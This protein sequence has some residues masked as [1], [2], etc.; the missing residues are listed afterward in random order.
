M[1]ATEIKLKEDIERVLEVDERILNSISDE[2]ALSIKPEKGET[3]PTY[4]D[5]IF[6]A[7]FIRN[8]SILLK[9]I[10][11]MFHIEEDINNPIAIIGYESVPI[12][13]NGKTFKSDLLVKLSDES[14]VVIEMNNN[15]KLGVID[16]N[17]IQLFRVHSQILKKGEIYNKLK[18]YRIRGIN[19]NYMIE[20]LDNNEVDKYAFCNV[21]TGEI[22]SDLITYVNI[23]VEKCYNLVYNNIEK[24]P[25][26]A[27]W[28]A[29]I[30]EKKIDNIIK[31]LGGELSM[32]EKE[33]LRKTYE[34]INDD[35]RVLKS[36]IAE[37][38]IRWKFEEKE[39]IGYQTGKED[40]K[41]TATIE[42]IKNMLNEK[43]DYN[44]I[45]KIT[46][47]T[48]EEIQEIEKNM[49]KE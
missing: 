20:E 1:L 7:V 31:I 24:A 28:G 34:D 5:V 22:A 9:M 2:E 39:E 27:K 21:R 25:I 30:K 15:S 8:Q 23:D 19:F 46:G 16:R 47:K 42:M 4:Y 17:L 44:T 14:Y 11:R 40:G 12:V 6:K 29:I 13:Y 10:K 49:N 41:E 26:E 38:N 37:D 36:W 33:E 43:I 48:I 18:D 3:L 45:S 32:E 35:S